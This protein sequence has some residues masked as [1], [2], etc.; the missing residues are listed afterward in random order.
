MF[1]WLGKNFFRQTNAG[2]FNVRNGKLI[3]SE[4]FDEYEMGRTLQQ[5]H[6]GRGDFLTERNDAVTSF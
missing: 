2:Q 5:T 1:D 6:A 3:R 4:R